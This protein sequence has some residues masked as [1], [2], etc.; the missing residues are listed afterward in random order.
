MAASTCPDLALAAALG[1]VPGTA[2]ETSAVP[3]DPARYIL[4]YRLLEQDRRDL[5]Y[6]LKLLVWVDR[7][8]LRADTAAGRAPR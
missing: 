5:F 3:R 1:S 7:A 8:L 6:R 4:A 2:A